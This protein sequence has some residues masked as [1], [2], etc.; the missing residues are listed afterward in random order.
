MKPLVVF[1]LFSLLLKVSY[2]ASFTCIAATSR[3]PL[4]SLRFDCTC[5]CASFLCLSLFKLVAVVVVVACVNGNAAELESP[6]EE[7][8]KTPIMPLSVS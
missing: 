6:S 3:R 1:S 5:M 8:C 7:D 4:R 2:W